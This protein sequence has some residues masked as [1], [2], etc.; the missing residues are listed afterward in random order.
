MAARRPADPVTVARV[1]PTRTAARRRRGSRSVRREAVQ[2]R[3]RVLL[4]RRHVLVHDQGR[5]PGVGVQRHEQHHQP[6]VRRLAGDRWLAP[7]TG[8]DNVTRSSR[9]RPVRGRGRREHGDLPHHPG[10]DRR[11]VPADPE[12]ESSAKSPGPRSAP[13]GSTG[14][15]SPRSVARPGAAAVGSPTKSLDRSGVDSHLTLLVRQRC[16]DTV[17][18]QLPCI[19]RRFLCSCAKQLLCSPVSPPCQSASPVPQKPRPAP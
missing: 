16:S 8:V 12:P 15:T 18:V 13:T 3:R 10:R 9:R 17:G 2:R 14:C 19:A 6:D 11:A 4:R 5:R 1:V 7:L